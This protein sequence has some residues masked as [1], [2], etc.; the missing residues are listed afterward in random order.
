MAQQD[1]V[2]E[3]QVAGRAPLDRRLDLTGTFGAEQ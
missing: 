2:A 3:P 1:A